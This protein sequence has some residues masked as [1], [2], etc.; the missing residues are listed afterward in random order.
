MV[1]RMMEGTY[2]SN[3]ARKA[4]VKN[5]IKSYITSQRA[6]DVR[7][8]QEIKSTPAYINLTTEWGQLDEDGVCI[9]V[10]RQALEETITAFDQAIALLKDNK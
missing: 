1:I 8:F 10:S 2:N 4:D 5:A 7:R 3:D 6:S 9:A